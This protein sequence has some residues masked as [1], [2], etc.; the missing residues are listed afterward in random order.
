MGYNHAVNNSMKGTLYIIS[1]PSG[2]GKTSLVKAL[3]DADPHLKVSVSHTTRTQREG[4]QDGVNYHFID[5]ATFA[6]MVGKGA[7]LEHAHVFGND[8]GTSRQW[9]EQQLDEAF[10]VILEIDWQGAQTV[11][12]AFPEAVSIFILPPSKEVLEQR[13]RDRG[14]DAED[15]IARRMQE[16]DSELSHQDEFKYKVINDDFSQALEALRGIVEARRSA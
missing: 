4:E 5:K 7:F 14:Q 3:V 2:A 8:Y 13:L 11:R 9:V 1:A 12:A 16:A 10:D 15:V 6:E